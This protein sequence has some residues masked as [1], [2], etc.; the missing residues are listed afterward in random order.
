M[1]DF[2][3]SDDVVPIGDFKARAAEWLE[4]VKNS[5]H[6]LLITRNGRPAGVLI[7]PFEFDRLQQRERFIESVAEGLADA[8]A[9][10]VMSTHEL[11][12][13]LSQRKNSPKTT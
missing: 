5:G 10:R 7:S 11:R 8:D 9:G 6:S 1:K 2:R 4:R 3:V 12:R 13:R